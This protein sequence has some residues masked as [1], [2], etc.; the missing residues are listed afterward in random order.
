M[1]FLDQ[2][3]IVKK[4]IYL[5]TEMINIQTVLVGLSQIDSSNSKSFIKPIRNFFV[6]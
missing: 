1:H 4:S 6:S 5:I 2:Q 3:Y